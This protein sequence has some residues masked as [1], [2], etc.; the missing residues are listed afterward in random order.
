MIRRL[1]TGLLDYRSRL[2]RLAGNFEVRIFGWP[3]RLK[4]D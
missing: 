1:L 2:L 3:T 4:N